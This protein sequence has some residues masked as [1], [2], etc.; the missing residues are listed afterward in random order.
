MNMLCDIAVEYTSAGT[1]NVGT[2]YCCVSC[3]F[4]DNLLDLRSRSKA[5]MMMQVAYIS[6]ILIQLI[7]TYSSPHVH[8]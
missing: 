4:V 6:R 1:K 3:V 5:M 8:K 7:V 2:C